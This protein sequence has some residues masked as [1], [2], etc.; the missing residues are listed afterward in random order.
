MIGDVFAAVNVETLFTGE[1]SSIDRKGR[2]LTARCKLGN[3][4]FDTQLPVFL[5]GVMCSHLRG[6]PGDGS[7]LISQGCTGPDA[8]MLKASWKFT[9]KIAAPISA[10][11]PFILNLSTLTGVGVKAAAAIAANAVFLNWFAY[12]TVEWGVGN[13]KKVRPILGS[14]VPVAGA[15]ALNLKRYFPS[16]PPLNDVV[17][18]YPG[19]D[20]MFS[21]CKAYDAAANPTGKFGNDLNFGGDPFTP[22]GN[23]STTGLPNL[24]MGGTKK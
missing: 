7:H 12:G 23:P 16:L 9:A 8:I 6:S 1:V 5:K 19:C 15:L 18:I 17:T 11:F 13:E 24:N 2:K 4:L 10:D 22:I 20:G 14:T 3:G 21:T